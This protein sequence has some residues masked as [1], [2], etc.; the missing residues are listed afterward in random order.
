MVAVIT[1]D[2]RLLVQDIIFESYPIAVAINVAFPYSFATLHPVGVQL[3]ISRALDKHANAL[4]DTV[5]HE[6][7]F[8]PCRLLETRRH[9]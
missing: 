1:Q 7:R 8:F 5:L 4:C 6:L 9:Y 3:R 2:D